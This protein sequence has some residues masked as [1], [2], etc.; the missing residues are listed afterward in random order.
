MKKT[1]RRQD[2]DAVE[3]E[4]EFFDDLA[5]FEDLLWHFFQTELAVVKGFSNAAFTGE[6]RY[7]EELHLVVDADL[8]E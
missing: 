5:R 7:A 8:F 4:Q 6:Y 3:R 1:Y 2:F